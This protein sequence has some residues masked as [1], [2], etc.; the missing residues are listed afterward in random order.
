MNRTQEAIADLEIAVQTPVFLAEI[1]YHLGLAYVAV[2]SLGKAEKSFRSELAGNPGNIE[3]M[4]QLGLLLQRSG[5]GD[6]N[7][8]RE[9]QR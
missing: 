2:G 9:A 1:N 8:L 3:T 4:L 6:P 7:K 5:T